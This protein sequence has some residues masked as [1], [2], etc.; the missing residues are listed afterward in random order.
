MYGRVVVYTYDEDKD[1]LEAKARAGVISIV[2]NTP[3]YI[4]YGVMFQDTEG[5][6]IS[7]WDALHRR[8]RGWNSP[9]DRWPLG[10]RNLR[11]VGGRADDFEPTLSINSASGTKFAPAASDEM[12]VSD[13][14]QFPRHSDARRTR[15]DGCVHG[16]PGSQ[17]S[18][19]RL[20]R[21]QGRAEADNRIR[22]LADAARGQRRPTRTAIFARRWPDTAGPT[23]S[24]RAAAH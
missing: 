23:R 8:P 6:S 16:E 5:V 9:P 4:S 13:E 11:D 10:T 20:P 3:G 18:A 24:W 19:H 22:P 1:E 14:A 2:T 12:G 7:Q 21:R 15:S 17:L